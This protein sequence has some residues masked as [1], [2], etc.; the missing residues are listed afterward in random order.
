MRYKITNEIRQY[1]RNNYR[2]LVSTDKNLKWTLKNLIYK[3]KSIGDK[4]LSSIC[5]ITG[6][7]ASKFNLKNANFHP[8]RNFGDT[9]NKTEEIKFNG[10]NSKFA[11]FIGIMLG[12]G[13]I[14][15][16]NVRIML[17]KREK[18]YKEYIKD[19][20]SVLFGIKLHEFE[21]KETNQLSL[22]KWS[23]RL[24]DLLVNFGL[25]RGNKINNKLGIPEW[26][27]N[28]KEYAKNCLRGLVDTDGCVYFCK[29]DKRMY[30][31]F[32]SASDI[33]L[34][35]VKDLTKKLG[36]NFV[37]S[38]KHNI[39]LYRREEIAKYINN[40]GFSNA[41][42]LNKKGL[43]GSLDRANNMGAK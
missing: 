12:D 8:E 9:L 20:S 1:L 6:T 28:R 35:E 2:S 16:N 4:Q 36:Y 41:K 23:V 26:I 37:S 11:E 14:Y 13:N 27:K 15:R 25:M 30:I 7:K 32:T 18:E 5:R 10:V 34:K 39:C 22:Y 40:V 43:W 31:K 38:G 29:R 33:L 19:L 21:N 24:S 42:H 3:N 17:D